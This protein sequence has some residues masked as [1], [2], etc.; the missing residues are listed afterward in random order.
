MVW[1]DGLSPSSITITICPST[2]F[3]YNISYN[4][5]LEII[6]LNDAMDDV[7]HFVD[8]FISK[9]GVYQGIISTFL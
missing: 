4:D 2:C 1:S 6:V 5:S 9:R 7:Q 8:D 3:T